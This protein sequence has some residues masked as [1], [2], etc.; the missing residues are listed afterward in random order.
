MNVSQR[1]V[2]I[3]NILQRDR[4][5]E[6]VELANKFDVSTMTIRRDLLIFEKQGLVT[7]TYGGAYLNK[8]VSIEPNFGLKAMQVVGYKEA[9]A[10]EAA[11]L[12]N[13]GDSIIID[14]GTTTLNIMKYIQ[15][16]K[17]TVITNSW[18]VASYQQGPS[19][20]KLIL[21]P[22]EYNELSAGTISSMTVNFYKNLYADKVFISTQGFSVER[23]ATVPSVDNA[24]VKQSILNAGKQKILLVDHTKFGKDFLAKHLDISE[25]DYIITDEEIEEHYL[26]SIK[27]KC[28]NVIVAKTH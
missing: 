23:G 25:L 3:F 11:K 24:L 15:N 20:N 18:P 1:R 19:K 26:K 5:I 27:N 21:A 10:I 17:V 8:G 7:L 13:E 4:S 9:I 14:C 22:G 2:E 6:V 12:I 16:K 28:K